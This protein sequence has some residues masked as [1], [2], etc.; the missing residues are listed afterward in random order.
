MSQCTRAVRVCAESGVC[1]LYESGRLGAMELTMTTP[2]SQDLRGRI[3]RCVAAGTSARSAAQRFDV[4]ASAAIKLL[5]RVRET[6]STAPA[7]I[8]G[9]RRPILEPH[10]DTLRKIAKSKPGITLREMRD[11][12]HERGISVKALSTICDMLHRLKVSYKKSLESR[13]A[14]SARCGPAP[15]P[16]AGVAG[17]DGVDQP[18]VSGR[19]RRVDQHDAA[20]RLGS[21]GRSPGRRRPAWALEDHDHRGGPHGKWG[22]RTVRN[23]WSHGG[24]AFRIYVE[25]VLAPELKPGQAV[26]IDNLSIHKVKGVK[27]AIQAAGASLLY[28][29]SYSPDLNPIEQFFAK[30]KELLRKAAART[31]EALWEA[32]GRHLD[33]FTAEECQNYLAHSGYEP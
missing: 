21:E 11:A 16:L 3:V 28:L 20:L 30:L 1:D 23:R 4:S 10:A 24:D 19:E 22:R 18:G 26:L 27:E 14:G 8:G 9:Y 13:R 15:P 7:K 12:L 33:E 31:K 2:L 25:E 6:G 17:L 29:P 5:Q 32:I